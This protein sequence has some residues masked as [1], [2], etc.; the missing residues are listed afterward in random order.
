MITK[1]RDPQSMSFLEHLEAL[2]WHIIR[3][4]IAILIMAML[5]FIAKSFLF[6]VLLFGPKDPNFLTYRGLCR[7][8]KFFE[9]KDSLCFQELPFSIQSRKVAGQFSVHIWTSISAGFIAAFPYVLYEFWKFITP[10]LYEKERKYSKGFIFICSTLFFMGVLF[11]Y[12]IIAPL[13]IHFLGGYQV[14]EQVI[15][16]FDIDSYIALVKTSVISCGLLFELPVIIF[17]LTKIGLVT[18]EFL[19]KYRK[20]ALV[21]VM[22]LAAVITP[23]DIASQ[24]IVSIPILILYEASIWICK[25]VLKK[26]EKASSS[27][28]ITL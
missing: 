9:W 17:F 11:G 23:P 12:F 18:P 25:L 24:V 21:S 27:N 19:K 3:A 1:P 13:S 6:D 4:I 2:R 5:A 8:S 20:F 16:E 14:S 7:L 26:E 10:A 28:S 15:N 22:I